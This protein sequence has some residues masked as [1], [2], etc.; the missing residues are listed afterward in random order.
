MAV[1]CF[2]SGSSS[3]KSR[4]AA[5]PS[6]AAASPRG[7]D[8]DQPVQR[9]FALL[10]ALLVADG[11]G[12]GA[13]GAAEAL[14]LVANDRLDGGE[15]LGRGHQAH[16]HAGAAEDGFDDF[17]VVEVGDDDAVLDGVAADDAA[18]GNLAD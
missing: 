4:A 3:S 13:L 11:A 6:D 10:D 14:A 5:K 8:I 15:Q 1:F 16:G 12:L 18:G 17:A 2:S 9:V 7:P